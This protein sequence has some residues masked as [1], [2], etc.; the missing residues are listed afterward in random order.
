MKTA[1]P[2][3][4]DRLAQL[5]D[6]LDQELGAVSDEDLSWATRALDLG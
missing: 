6:D 4:E 2:E 1:R 3:E 5:L